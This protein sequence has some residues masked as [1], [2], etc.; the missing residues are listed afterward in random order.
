VPGAKIT[1]S[2]VMRD[3]EKLNADGVGRSLGFAFVNFTRHEH[4]LAALREVNN[5][6]EV[7]GP[8]KRPIVEFALENK[9]ALAIKRQRRKRQLA[10][11]ELQAK[12]H[13]DGAPATKR[14]KQRQKRRDAK[15]TKSDDN[16]KSAGEKRKS[17]VS[18]E[19][20]SP[21]KKNKTNPVADEQKNL[22]ARKAYQGSTGTTTGGKKVKMPKHT[23]P[24]IRHRDKGQ[25][26]ERLRASKKLNARK[27]QTKTAPDR[28][29]ERKAKVQSVKKGAGRRG[30]RAKQNDLRED[31]E[32]SKLVEKYTQQFKANMGATLK[33]PKWFET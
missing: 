27:R 20:K 9:Q 3:R 17:D 5:S 23:G 33:K 32:F 4:A 7:F 6:P 2:R 15:K 31:R 21:S 11:N 16:T 14:S 30:N 1:E 26:L 24:K 12:M 25:V 28:N 18:V 8:A 13:P 22:P 10:K 19:G 29:A